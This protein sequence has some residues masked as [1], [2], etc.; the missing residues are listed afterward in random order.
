MILFVYGTTGELIKLAPVMR[1][2]ADAD[3]PY[4]SVSTNQQAKQIGPMCDELEL[5]HPD[6]VLWGGVRGHDLSRPWQIP[7]WAVV[8]TARFLWLV[9][10]IKRRLRRQ[11]PRNVVMVHGD[12]ITTVAGALMGRC[13]RQPVAHLEAG[14][15][16]HDW[17]H[18][19]PE[20]LNRRLVARLAHLNYA[21]NETAVFN[22]R[23]VKGEI[24]D[25]GANTVRDSLELVPAR[26]RPNLPSGLADMLDEPF[27]L[28]S[29]HRF[30]L[31]AQRETLTVLLELLAKEAQR[32]R[33][34]FVDHPVTVARLEQYEL[35][36][37]FDADRFV[38]VPR[39]SY[40]NFIALL[41]ASDYLVTDSGG[42]QEECYFLDHPCL[43]HR[44]AS[45]RH[46]GI[47]T[48][49]VLSLFDLDVVRTFLA[50][51]DRHRVGH[52]PEV[53][54]P[55][56]VVVA[57]LRTRGYLGSGGASS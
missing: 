23:G 9:P 36:H 49:V 38:R 44:M 28:V 42:A 8:L 54:S 56:D 29:I 30:E 7:L 37:L 25:I 47:G 5:Q 27:G 6:Y 1:R 46:E 16:S 14:L 32:T 43:V 51:P 31:L 17:R 34:L 45:E 50:D 26:Q 13:L 4:L 3:E 35:E 48:N 20:E 10:R 2:L 41:R 55:S 52:R 18:P 15:R 11:S 57:D 53:R 12:T 24:V 33:L 39:Q 21:P 19:F 40:L 22:L